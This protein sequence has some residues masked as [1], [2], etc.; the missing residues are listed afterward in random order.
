MSGDI[1]V[2][3]DKHICSSLQLFVFQSIYRSMT[4]ASLPIIDLENDE[5][6][7][8]QSI[9]DVCST[10]G[11]FYLRN[12][13]L[14]DAQRKMFALSKEYF[15]LPADVK[16]QNK[17]N[18]EN[19]GYLPRGRENLDSTK[20]KEVDEKEAFNFKKV[21][22]PS[23]LPSLFAQAENFAL[24]T[25]FHRACFDLTMRLLTYLAKSFG[26]ADD[27]FSSRHR[28]EAET[29]EIL[30]LLRYPP[31]ESN[32]LRAG[33]HSDYGSL[34]LLFQH[35]HQSGLEVLDR[36]SNIW[37]P[38]SPHDDMLVVNFGDVAE[39]WSKGLIK[40]IV[41]RVVMPTEKNTERF[42][43]VYFAHPELSA[44]L[45]PIPSKVIIDR[46]F[47]K[48][49]HAQHALNHQNEEVLTAGEHLHMRLRQTHV[50]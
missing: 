45:T 34:S 42:S 2:G 15:Q 8:V 3:S 49:S 22:H 19:F 5:S 41:H 12:H 40:S 24:I 6:T 1:V 30:R 18:H 23:E 10:T 29:S 33:A 7:I 50:L 44:L 17:I 13:G 26:V 38:V 32:G 4:F 25:S 48:D 11:F 46:E 27:Y 43:I 35:E 37:Y 21:L 14:I 47:I 16:M 28:W 39:Y 36:S 31:S 9:F 20:G